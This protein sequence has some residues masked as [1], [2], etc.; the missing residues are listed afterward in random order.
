MFSQADAKA[1][2]NQ[3]LM[4]GSS[5]SEAVKTIDGILKEVLDIVSREK[6]EQADTAAFRNLFLPTA[7]FTMHTHNDSMPKPV[8]SVSLDQFIEILADPYY[9]EGFEEIELNKIVD[10][11]NGIAH[12]FQTYY[13]KDADGA[14]EKGLNSYQLIYF[15]NRWWIVSIM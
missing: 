7:R 13:V 6:G 12:V 15:E 11:Y 8:E 1:D 14:E 4:D 2:P 10:E 3:L 9:S 5:T